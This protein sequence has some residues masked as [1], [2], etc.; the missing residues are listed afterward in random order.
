MDVGKDILSGVAVRYICV[1]N[2]LFMYVILMKVVW[3]K[4]RKK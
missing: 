4:E 2:F 3:L 1:D